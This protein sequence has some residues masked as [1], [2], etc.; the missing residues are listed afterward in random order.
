[1]MKQARIWILLLVA[2]VWGCRQEADYAPEEAAEG[3]KVEIIFSFPTESIPGTKA[4][5][6]DSVDEPMTRLYLAVFGSSGYLKEYVQADPV[7]L[8]GDKWEYID[9]DNVPRQAFQYTFRV[10]LSIADNE[11]TIH[12]LGNGPETISFGYQDAVVPTILSQIGERAYW[13]RIKVPKISAK[14]SSTTYTDDNGLNVIPGDYIDLEGNKITNGKGY[15][16]DDETL[17]SFSHIPL[18]RNWA[19]VVVR[20]DE[21]L[22][23]GTEEI[24]DP[25]FDPISYAVVNVPARGT[26]AP[27]CAATG[28][29][30][31]YQNKSF[32]DL[33]T[34]GYTAN[35]PAGTPFDDSVPSAE[36]FQIKGRNP[37]VA[38]LSDEDNAVYLYERPVPSDKIP[39]TS[40]IIYGTYRNP[41]PAEA[42]YYGKNYYY[43][44]DLMESSSYY[45]I[46]RNFKYQI[47]V[48][49]IRSHGHYSPEAAAAA[50]GSADVSADINTRN[51]NDISDGQGRLVVR[52]W[53]AKTF[54]QKQT[55][56]VELSAYFMKDIQSNLVDMDENSVTL[57]LL[58]R[59]Y[60]APDIITDYHIHPPITDDPDQ[61]GWRNIHFTTVEPGLTIASQTLRVK[62][63][64]QSTSGQNISLY[65]D[66]VITVQPIQPMKVHCDHPKVPYVK[67]SE[68]A[69][70]ISIPD[71]L[72]ESMFPLQF[73]IE[74][75]K[76][77]LTP[78]G[79]K[80]NNNLPVE[81]GES[82]SGS[83]KHSFHFVRTLSWREYQS[84]PLNR[85]E[86]DFSWRHFTCYFKT[87]RDVSASTIWVENEYFFTGSDS[88]VNFVD[89][90]YRILEFCTSV[91]R[92]GDA[93]V[94]I[95]MQ[96][97][98]D[99]GCTYPDDFPQVAFDVS[100]MTPVSDFVSYDNKIHKY[101]FKPTEAYMRLDFMTTNT[102]GDVMA[103]F[104]AE[105]Y[106]TRTLKSHYFSDFKFVDA[107][108][109][110]GINNNRSNVILG[111]INN[112][113]NK[114]VL[115]QYCEDADATGVPVWLRGL[116]GL[117]YASPA[118]ADYPAVGLSN[119]K[120]ASNPLF[121][122]LDFRTPG[123][124]SNDPVSFTLC[125]NG[126]VEEYVQARRFQ[127]SFV[128]KDFTQ[129]NMMDK[130]TPDSPSFTV[131]LDNKHSCTVTFSEISSVNKSDPKGI[132]LNAG[133]TYTLDFQ[134]T[135]DEKR[136]LYYIELRM[137]NS[138]KW[139]GVTRELFPEEVSVSSGT[140][141]RWGNNKT[142]FMWNASEG[143]LR[144][145]QITFK[146]KDECPINIYN[147]RINTYQAT[148]Y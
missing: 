63:T 110:K 85:E 19:K 135:G 29:I 128:Y 45:P 5:G 8:Q 132:I 93:S 17:A 138:Y 25:F 26:L 24:N 48:H 59:S 137:R 77:T 56:N 73:K 94:S 55:N 111:R 50:A 96:M 134:L 7:V 11:R 27:H 2:L 142:D 43:K 35:L 39:S 32:T 61:Y 114:A 124:M 141:S 79:S 129:S 16:A 102:D 44:I 60:N 1:M 53:M 104:E 86:E 97:R 51:L 58:P 101:V 36:D 148:F 47:L 130:L 100:G 87:N 112:D 95:A 140:Y 98:E 120:N 54:T 74:A 84:L 118:A 67:G 146:A 13:Q 69:V 10:T 21:G 107:H 41:D 133:G 15:V 62:G 34:L 89:D 75:E 38:F 113:A 81:E 78:D 83:G 108:D 65:R 9:L 30:D 20:K 116:T 103:T 143:G 109:L 72:V 37:K 91:P 90:D 14:K 139:E 121:R 49:K 92:G 31:D 144:H 106:Q 12:F 117:V 42:E 99:A 76:M 6:E 22:L 136:S 123:T 18:I 122:E 3:G 131:A 4:L 88:F 46:Y 23:P 33:E 147:I 82:L 80:S 40:V 119:G 71:G 66:I 64:Y 105:G 57:E 115:F 70:T 125:A 52:D 28:F 68:E 127:G 145:V 126:Y